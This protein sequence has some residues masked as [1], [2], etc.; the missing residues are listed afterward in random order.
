MYVLKK[1]NIKRKPYTRT[2]I[3]NYVYLCNSLFIYSSITAVTVSLA[4]TGNFWEGGSLS[5]TGKPVTFSGHCLGCLLWLSPWFGQAKSYWPL[6]VIWSCCR[7]AQWHRLYSILCIIA[8]RICPTFC[9][10]CCTFNITLINCQLLVC[11]C[12]MQ[13]SQAGKFCDKGKCL[14]HA[15]ICKKKNQKEGDL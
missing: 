5:F 15:G 10:P 11:L 7:H 12:K 8:N 6:T 9:T 4:F 3:S 2:A 1:K 13:Y 14:T